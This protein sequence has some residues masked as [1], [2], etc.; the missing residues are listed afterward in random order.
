MHYQANLEI[1]KLWIRIELQNP[2]ISPV[3]LTILNYFAAN[4]LFR[5]L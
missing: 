5:H 3:V 2:L 4:P 1:P